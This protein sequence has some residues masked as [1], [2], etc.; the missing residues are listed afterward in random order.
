MAIGQVREIIRARA[1]VLTAEMGKKETDSPTPSTGRIRVTWQL[2]G[3][4]EQTGRNLR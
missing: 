4:G 3:H 2:M 1:G